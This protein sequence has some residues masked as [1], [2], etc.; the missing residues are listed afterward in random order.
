VIR[1]LL[2]SRSAD[3]APVEAGREETC[4]SLNLLAHA[5]LLELPTGSRCGGHGK[6]GGDRILVRSA[7]ASDLSP[8]TEAERRHLTPEELAA[9]VRIACQCFPER[10]GAEIEVTLAGAAKRFGRDTD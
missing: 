6:C 9:G 8:V 7:S 4:R 10:D 3:G 2:P 5:Q 1:F